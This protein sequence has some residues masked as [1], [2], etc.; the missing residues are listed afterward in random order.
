MAHVVGK[1]RD[2]SLAFFEEVLALRVTASGLARLEEKSGFLGDLSAGTWAPSADGR[3]PNHPTAWLPSERV[4]RAWQAMVRPVAD[5][6]GR[7]RG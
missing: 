5:S 1:S 6:G 2:V 3:V 4:A 7:P